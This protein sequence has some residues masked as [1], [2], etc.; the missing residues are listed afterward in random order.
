MTARAPLQRVRLQRVGGEGGDRGVGRLQWGVVWVLGTVGRGGG[1]VGAGLLVVGKGG[2][3][4]RGTVATVFCVT[5]VLLV[6]GKVAWVACWHNL[7]LVMMI[8]RQTSLRTPLVGVWSPHVGHPS[9]VH[10][11]CWLILLLAQAS[12]CKVGTFRQ[13]LISNGKKSKLL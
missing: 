12:I 1:V 2:Q 7:A 11:H 13:K 10:T 6:V 5:G 9:P 3:R 8:P 4:S